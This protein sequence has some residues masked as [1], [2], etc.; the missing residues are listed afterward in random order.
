[1]QTLPWTETVHFTEEV[2]AFFREGRANA[3]FLPVGPHME[4][5]A[6]EVSHTKSKDSVGKNNCYCRGSTYTVPSPVLNSLQIL[7]S[8]TL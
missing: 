4:A 2:L 3:S 8:S 1:M 5:S 7:S 6:V